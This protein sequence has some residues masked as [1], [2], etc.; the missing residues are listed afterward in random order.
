MDHANGHAPNWKVLSE[1][2]LQIGRLQVISERND[3]SINDL[4]WE[5]RAARQEWSTSIVRAHERID[6]HKRRSIPELTGMSVKELLTYAILVI[7]AIN[8]TLNGETL[9]AWLT[10]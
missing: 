1:I 8:G 6:S 9:A 10:K 5:V 2:Q 7:L 3:Q 4:R